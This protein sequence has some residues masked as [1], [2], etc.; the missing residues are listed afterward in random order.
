VSRPT[1]KVLFI[2]MTEPGGYPPLINAACV[3]SGEGWAPTFLSAPF[4]GH[5]LSMPDMPELQIEALPPRASHVVTRAVYASYCRQAFVVA[6][7]LK[8]DLVY[9]SDAIGALAGLI[10]AQASGARLVYHEH[11]SPNQQSDLNPLMQFARSAAIRR[12]H[13]IIFPN[14]VRAEH[15]R[16]QLGFDPGR[17]VIAW[18]VPRRTEVFAKPAS[19]ARSPFYLYYHGSIT[20]DRLPETVLVAARLAGARV[21]V[22]GYE[23]PSSEGYMARMVATYGAVQEGGLIDWMGTL[24][25]RSDCLNSAAACHLG[26]TLVPK[27]SDD[28]NMQNM[29]GASNKAFD[30]M[31]A[32][33]P[34]IV[35]NLQDWETLYVEPG[36]GIAA[37]PSDVGSLTAA[38]RSFL[39][40][41]E[42]AVATGDAN[43][44]KILSDWNYECQFAPV[45]DRLQC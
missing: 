44:S 35:S 20:P 10:A 43:R 30:Y 40:N 32:G 11:D 39:D 37:D 33:L 25:Q 28:I 38:I 9:C 5:N 19:L 13:T 17:L 12:A 16:Q 41:P 3:L 29:A 6:R 18:N 1:R 26:L 8:P 22:V 14:A 34:L 45:L 21:R 2:Q 15:A 31:A 23:T 7:K 36:H 42:K 24:P 27:A 4:V